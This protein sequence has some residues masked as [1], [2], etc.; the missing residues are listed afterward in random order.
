MGIS[1]SIPET[2]Q[3]LYSFETLIFGTVML[4]EV[5]QAGWARTF[6]IEPGTHLLSLSGNDISGVDFGNAQLT[7]PRPLQIV[8]A[9]NS[10]IDAV[11]NAGFNVVANY[12]TSDND[13]TLSGLGL[14]LHFDSSVMTFD[15][16]VSVLDTDLVRQQVLNDAD[17]FDNDPVTD[18]YLLVGWANLQDAWPD[19]TL[20]VELYTARF[21]LVEDQP[22]DTMSTMRFTASSTAVTHNFY[23]EP[24][25]VSVIEASLD[26]DDNGTADALSDGVLILRYL[27]GFRGEDLVDHALATNANRSDPSAIAEYLGAISPSILDADASGDANALTDG[28]LILRYLLGFRGEDLIDGAVDPGGARKNAAEIVTFLDQFHPQPLSVDSPSANADP[29]REIRQSL[30]ATAFP[31]HVVRGRRFDLEM[32]YTGEVTGPLGTSSAEETLIGLGFRLHYDSSFL[33][34]DEVFDRLDTGF[35]LQKRLND[36]E[37]FDN[38]PQTDKYILTAFF[39]ITG[40][41]PG[42]GTLPAQLFSVDFRT[43]DENF[44]TDINFTSTATSEGAE[45]IA[46]SIQIQATGP[47]VNR[48]VAPRSGDWDN[49]ENWSAG[50]VPREID[51]VVIDVANAAATITVPDQDFAVNSLVSSE[52]LVINGQLHVRDDAELVNLELRQGGLLEVSGDLTITEGVSTNAGRLILHG[53]LNITAA[54]F[55]N[56][57]TGILQMFPSGEISPPSEPIVIT[58]GSLLQNAGTME[59]QNVGEVTISQASTLDNQ[60]GGTFRILPTPQEVTPPTQPIVISEGSLLQ[61][62]GNLFLAPGPITISPGSTLRN[63]ATGVLR[64][65]PASDDLGPEHAFTVAGVLENFGVF[66]FANPVDLTVNGGRFTNGGQVT[67]SAGGSLLARERLLD[68]G[69]SQSLVEI[70]AGAVLRADDCCEFT[71]DLQNGSR[72]FNA[73]TM[74]LSPLGTTSI[75]ANSIFRNESTGSIRYAP[76]PDDLGPEHAFKVAGVLENFGVFDFA[77]PVDLT[78]NGGRF[79]NGGQ[80]TFS[81]GGSL[82]AQERPLDS[83]TSQSLVEILAGAILRADDCCQFTLDLQNG[84]RLFNAGTMELSPLGTTSIGAN[85]IFRNESTGSIRYAPP[86]DDLGPEHAF[87][88]AGVLENFGVFDFANPVDLTVNGGRFTNGGQV[89]FSAGGSLLAQERPLDSGTSQSLVEILAGAIL[90]AEDCCNFT[91]D[92]QNGSRLF[93]AGTMELSPLGTTSIGANSI[94]RNESTGSIRYAPP[95]DDLGPE[96]AFTVAGVL[97]NLGTL[98]FANPVDLTVNG[99]R[100]TNGGQVTFSAGGSLL[101]QERPLDSGTS[102]SLVEILAGAILRADD[103]CEFTLD[104]QNG[105]R[106]FNAGTM[107]LSPLGTTSIGANSIFRNESTGSIRYAPPADDLGPEHAFTVAGVLENFGAIDFANPMELTVNGG[108]FTNGGQVTFSAGGSLL[109]Q[110]RPL[111][112][113][114]SQSLV[115]ILAG[116]V[117]RAEDCCEFTLDLQNS[118]RLVSAGR[119]VLPAIGSVAVNGTSRL[120]VESNLSLPNFQ[121]GP[122]ARLEIPQNTATLTGGGLSEGTIQIDENGELNIAGDYTLAEG[123]RITGTGSLRIDPASPGST[124]VINTDLSL[125]RFV[126]GTFA[127]HSHYGHHHLQQRCDCHRQPGPRGHGHDWEFGDKLLRG[128]SRILAGGIDLPRQLHPNRR[129]HAGNRNRRHHARHGA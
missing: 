42:T 61:N 121:L 97:E 111:D 52:I 2:E 49:P 92:L 122:M 71:L 112:S 66:D 44:T 73:G 114:T 34:I 24:I 40:E 53:G 7:T 125:D 103:C 51:D 102:Q 30:T 82:L 75:G 81:A 118:S 110:E 45:F 87:T 105:S 77:N 69:T 94:F 46:P 95:A 59:L 63:Q 33:D 60:A 48:W 5:P 35:L 17:D 14:R 68:S 25:N 124:V 41:W 100:F 64:Y 116:A 3:G 88:V 12:T 58:G 86:P 31:Q 117:L 85:S 129:R 107:E 99:G 127:E 55:D 4:A 36:L 96:H 120:V 78:V 62:A 93:N 115:E 1:R 26:V 20:P 70:L 57:D 39:D 79:T 74:E 13:P 98:D 104:L 10:T 72:L 22:I 32:R 23:S 56:Q 38:D 113:G 9:Q 47:V 11:Q 106:L 18:Q 50:F 108:R 90:R 6:P 29:A 119:L 80:V 109:A 89:T 84:S 27:F 76:P 37:D 8:T 128:S 67:F 15:R 19:Q 83:G 101:A 21:Q 16:L 126:I 28:T 43:V 123:S 65:V 54:V 91:L